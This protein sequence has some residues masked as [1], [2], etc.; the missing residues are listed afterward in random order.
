MAHNPVISIGVQHVELLLSRSNNRLISGHGWPRLVTMEAGHGRPVPI[1]L[2]E[3]RLLRL[4]SGLHRRPPLS[5]KRSYKM[6]PGMIRPNI[7]YLHSHDTGRC[8]SPYGYAVR[9]PNLQKFAEEGTLFRQAFCA[10]PTCSPS[11]AA[12]LTGQWA[13]TAGIMGLAHC[14]FTLGDMSQHLV[15]TLK[16]AGYH[17]V[18]GGVQHVAKTPE[19]IG[20]DQLLNPASTCVAD[21]APS[22]HGIGV[23][24]MM[25]GLG[26]PAGHVVDAMVSHVDVFPTICELT[27]ITPPAWLQGRSIMPLVRGQV[28]SIRDELFAEVN[29]HAAYEPMRAVRTGRY[30]Y[31]RRYSER[32]IPVR[33]NCDEGESKRHWLDLGWSQRQVA[34]EQ[35]YDLAFDPHETNN[36]AALPDFA[37]VVAPMRSRLQRWMD[38]TDDPI[39]SGSLSIPAGVQITPVNSPSPDSPC[40]T[41][42]TIHPAE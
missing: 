4:W 39:R 25:R 29:F 34:H 15:H 9:T 14:G 1:L 21:A 42:T 22:D 7:I 40:E 33:S 41:I 17:T 18:L 38:D 19:Q 37:D 28:D 13:H 30:K 12:L 35:L 5:P 27:N 23:M 24:L 2:P 16:P 26:F 20:Y 36:L 31:I 6:R 10:N 11:R 3:L 32:S 8:A